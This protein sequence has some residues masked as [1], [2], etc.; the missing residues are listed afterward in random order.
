MQAFDTRNPSPCDRINYNSAVLQSV[1]CINM[2]LQLFKLQN[3]RM[4]RIVPPTTESKKANTE[5]E[6]K[7]HK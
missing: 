6:K 5:K 4:S 7:E 2:Q 3:D 1:S